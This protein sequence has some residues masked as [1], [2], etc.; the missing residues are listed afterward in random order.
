MSIYISNAFVPAIKI[1]SSIVPSG[2]LSISENG[3]YGITSY[4][5]LTVNIQDHLDQRLTSILTISS[6]EDYTATKIN[7]GAFAYCSSVCNINMPNV[8]TIG[9]FAFFGNILPSGSYTWDFPKCSSIDYKAFAG[10]TGTDGSGRLTLNLTSPNLS[11]IVANTI[12]T[13]NCNLKEINMP[14]CVSLGYN[15]QTFYTCKNLEKVTLTSC[16]KLTSKCFGSCTSLV[17]VSIPKVTSVWTQA[18]N[19]CTNL[20][21][22]SLPACV[23]LGT[24][25]F[26]HCYNLLSVYLNVSSMVTLYN[27]T[28][29]ISTPISTYTTSTGGVYGSIYVPTS[30]YS[31]FIASTNWVFYSSRIVSMNF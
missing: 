21:T 30:L 28:V 3:L 4:A 8:E 7:S 12:F 22:I 24:S 14:Y 10:V 23:Y 11:S 9:A 13:S 29:F 19:Y 31:T 25:C 26:S 6:Y 5:S 2:T 15:S 17:D 16:S 27:S 1:N 18:F 20:S